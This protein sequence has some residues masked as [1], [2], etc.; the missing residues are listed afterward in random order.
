MA[1]RYSW[2]EACR[3]AGLERKALSPK[4]GKSNPLFW[5]ARVKFNSKLMPY[6]DKPANFVKVVK[7]VEIT[8]EMYTEMTLAGKN[9][10]KVIGLVK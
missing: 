5:I 1:L 3:V 8:P 6:L 9:P 2:G 7:E 10:Y 4:G